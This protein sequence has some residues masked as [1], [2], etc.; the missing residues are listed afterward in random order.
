MICGIMGQIYVSK[1]IEICRILGI[2][3]S[4]KMARPCQMTGKLP[5]PSGDLQLCGNDLTLSLPTSVNEVIQGKR[6]FSNVSLN[7]NVS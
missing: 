4:I 5:L 1:M 3:F 6:Q 7:C 2:S